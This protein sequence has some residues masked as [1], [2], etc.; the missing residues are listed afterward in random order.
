MTNFLI[1]TLPKVYLLLQY[2]CVAKN[3][4]GE[5]K[6]SFELG[7]QALPPNFTKKLNSALDVLQDEPL[8]LECSLD[9]SPLPTVQWLKDGDEIKASPRY[10]HSMQKIYF[11]ASKDSV[12]LF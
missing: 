2:T 7:L 11:M 4:V 10:L 6:I 3:E 1:K 5:T 9:G 8:V 12:Y